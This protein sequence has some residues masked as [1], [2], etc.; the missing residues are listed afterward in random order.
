MV[1]SSE[2]EAECVETVTSECL[3]TS[4]WSIQRL[5]ADGRRPRIR[6]LPESGRT[7]SEQQRVFTNRR[8]K[9]GLPSTSPGI[10]FSLQN[11]VKRKSKTLCRCALNL[12]LCSRQLLTTV[13]SVYKR[14]IRSYR[15]HSLSCER[16]ICRRLF[17]N[18]W[19]SYIIKRIHHLHLNIS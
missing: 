3:G 12:E 1:R 10:E 2:S 13:G 4:I 19:L 6:T 7:F 5:T 17:S 14:N 11:L 16:L 9:L 8:L 15:V 18:I